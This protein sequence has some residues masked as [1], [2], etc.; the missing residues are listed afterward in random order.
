M[1]T[2]VVPELILEAEGLIERIEVDP[3]AGVLVVQSLGQEAVILDVWP[4]A[5]KFFLPLN[6]YLDHVQ[7]GW[8]YFLLTGS[9]TDWGV[10]GSGAVDLASG[11]AFWQ[12]TLGGRWLPCRYE[13]LWLTADQSTYRFTP[14]GPLLDSRSF[15]QPDLYESIRQRELDLAQVLA[16]AYWVDA[17]DPQ[18][19]EVCRWG[20]QRL[21]GQ[22]QPS[23]LWVESGNYR[24]WAALTTCTRN[25]S[26]AVLLYSTGISDFWLTLGTSD[27]LALPDGLML[28]NCSLWYL[29]AGKR[30]YR[31]ADKLTD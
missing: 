30:L 6:A 20:F 12:E 7:H 17:D 23:I 22:P 5:R 10:V 2:Q 26:Q 21:K 24:A 13:S 11:Q 28:W 27:S 25:Q 1:S 3:Y 18:Y 14:E 8:A 31:I 16:T 19:P 9:G 15:S 29:L 4:S